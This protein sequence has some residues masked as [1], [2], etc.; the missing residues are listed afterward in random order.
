MAIITDPPAESTLLPVKTDD[1]TS[2]GLFLPHEGN[3][4]RMDARRLR[5]S[6]ILIDAL[7]EGVIT[8]T[9]VQAL[10][11]AAIESLIDSSPGALDTLNEL[12]AALG[13][14]PN[15]AA[16][17]TQALA[18]KAPLASPTFTGVP[19]APT[20]AVTVN[21]TQLATTAFV[22]ALLA[23]GAAQGG[24][25]TVP[26]AAVDD[27]D[28]SPASTAFV[29][30]QAATGTLLRALTSNTRF[31]TP[32]VMADAMEFLPIFVDTAST[33][34]LDLSAG[35]NRNY[36]MSANL[37]LGQVTNGK[38][39]EPVTLRFAQDVTGGRTLAFQ[40][41]YH[42]FPSGLIPTLS[43]AANALDR[44]VGICKLRGS[45]L[46]MEWGALEKDIK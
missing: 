23:A 2:R 40:S 45:T 32:K 22:R 24:A 10:I 7:F 38:D 43:T 5:A 27:N 6:L 16:T 1:R 18:A 17:M 28:T 36:S 30:A 15:F 29:L 13:D 12:A 8:Q 31:V 34:A 14:D 11:D 37:T 26:T 3:S 41:T 42:K 25:W 19:K 39:G 46:V 4:A 9:A 35:F 20:A 21:D 44:L 33:V